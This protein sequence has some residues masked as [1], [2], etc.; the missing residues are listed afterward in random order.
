MNKSESYEQSQDNN[1]ENHINYDSDIVS[2]DSFEDDASLSSYSTE[3]SLGI[4]E[5]NTMYHWDEVPLSEGM[6]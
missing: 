1:D 2:D 5:N 4:N 3:S 6:E